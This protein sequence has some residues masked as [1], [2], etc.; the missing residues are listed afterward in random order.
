MCLQLFLFLNRIYSFSLVGVLRWVTIPN[1]ICGD[2]GFVL[3]I[4]SINN[5]F[6]RNYQPSWMH[7]LHLIWHDLLAWNSHH[8]LLI[9]CINFHIIYKFLTLNFVKLRLILELRLNARKSVG[10]SP[11]NFESFPRKRHGGSTFW[12]DV[13]NVSSSHKIRS[14]A[15][16]SNGWK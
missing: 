10:S 15:L 8:N 1:H 12:E 2:L 13:T 14:D 16:F 4:I 11:L 5:R 7:N 6:L 3:Y 9:S